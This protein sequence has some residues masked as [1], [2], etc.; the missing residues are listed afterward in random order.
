V[1]RSV[2]RSLV[3]LSLGCG[4]VGGAFGLDVEL[5]QNPS[6]E[7]GFYS[8]TT[9]PASW[10]ALYT[11]QFNHTWVNNFAH[12]GRRC[13]RIDGAFN[14]ESDVR[15]YWDTSFSTPIPIVPTK[16]YLFQCWYRTQG[17]TTTSVVFRARHLWYGTLPGTS[18]D[19]YYQIGT[20]DQYRG[21]ADNWTQVSFLVY[22]V[23][24]EYPALAVDSLGNP[25]GLSATNI[26][27]SL[28]LDNSP[29]TVWFDDISLKEVNSPQ[30]LDALTPE[31]NWTPPPIPTTGIQPSLL[32]TG[33]YSI[34]EAPDGAFH[35]VRPD[36]TPI[37]RVTIQ[38]VDT[39][40]GANPCHYNWVL[41]NFSDTGAYRIFSRDRVAVAGFNAG[42]NYNSPIPTSPLF[43]T[44]FIYNFNF[45]NDPI[46]M[47]DPTTMALRNANGDLIGSPSHRVADPYN[48][49]W[50]SRVVA[51]VNA[52]LSSSMLRDRELV[53]YYTDN[54]MP[55]AY[56]YEFIWSDSCEQEFINWLRARYGN[57]IAALNAAWTSP[58]RTVNLSSF[59]DF[60]QSSTQKKVIPMGFGDPVGVDLDL[61]QRKVMRDYFEFIVGEIRRREREVFGAG[62]D[63]VTPLVTHLIVA[64][65]F[66]VGGDPDI[67]APTEDYIFE[68][69][70]DINAERPGFYF[71]MI[72]V[73]DYPAANLG[74]DHVPERNMAHLQHIHDVTGLPLIVSEFGVAA[75]ESEVGNSVKR[76]RNNTLDTQEQ[77]GQAYRN[78][79]G[80]WI[81]TPFIVGAEWFQWENG[82]YQ[83]GSAFPCPIDPEASNY[84]G[85]NC[86]VVSDTDVPY[87][88]L[89]DAMAQ[90]NAL[91]NASVRV[92]LPGV[93]GID[94]TS[95]V[96][97]QPAPKTFTDAGLVGNT[98]VLRWEPST[99]SDLAGYRIYHSTHQDYGW[100]LVANVPANATQFID[101]TLGDPTETH[102][103]R[104]TAYDTALNESPW[105]DPQQPTEVVAVPGYEVYR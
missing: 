16:I 11:S 23:N 102:F 53:G 28:G 67:F 45:S 80:T 14:L 36:G 69:I 93:A 30:E 71:D 37:W 92:N 44:A 9:N 22:P 70:R 72:A 64:N 10:N 13:V 74:K 19:S 42:L 27:I 68:T 90:T 57:N 5:V 26:R 59:D 50:R 56:L 24:N 18:G 63:G 20:T 21:P 98:A 47:S 82:Y 51:R 104:I 99:E 85:R 55:L 88:P 73:N 79:I 39:Y 83:G 32:P 17:V 3:C 54:E 7:L 81:N 75:R 35:L 87:A 84:D 91:V 94:W 89:T 34:Q 100:S 86:G 62:S 2:H 31:G 97:Y 38:N 41:G 8:P 95:S 78:L 15:P 96:G 48:P 58:Y 6:L 1:A 60:L 77:R 33:Y 25:V 61:F 101:E 29:G 76:W 66:P 65:R 4:L 49:V 12:L 105:L 52:V 46:T 103:F 40:A 43:S